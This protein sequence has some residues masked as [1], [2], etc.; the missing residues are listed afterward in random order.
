MRGTPEAARLSDTEYRIVTNLVRNRCGLHLDESKR[1]LVE[2]HLSRLIEESGHGSV[3]SYLYQIQ[4]GPNAEEEMSEV[5]D[6]L[7]TNETYFFRDRVQLEV[8]VQEIVPD[9]LSH[10]SRGGQPVSIWSA[11]CSSGEEPYSIVMLAD[12]MGLQAGR[13]FK[14]FASDISRRGLAQAR[15]GIYG[16]ASFS[17]TEDRERERYFTEED[18]LMRVVDEV[19]RGVDFM[20]MNLLD[21]SKA[22]MFGVMD[23]VLCRNVIGHFEG[24][25]KQVLIDRLYENLVPGG[26][27]L[28]G[29]AES[30]IDISS[31]FELKHCN[32]DLVYRKPVL[33][34]EREDPW[35]RPVYLRDDG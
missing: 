14:V 18:G 20:R 33:G 16:E 4:N 21:P 31:K 28:L 7:T 3:T 35:H 22:G 34:E 30:L 24:V 32:R 17:E 25:A 29:H 9:I 13:D 27:L 23:I 6:L 15:R 1:S 11:G 19:R 2:K 12:Q 26:H 5:I 8:L 10:R